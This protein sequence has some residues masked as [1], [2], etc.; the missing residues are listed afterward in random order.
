M[1]NTYP[2]AIELRKKPVDDCVLVHD[3]THRKVHVLNT[4]AAAILDLCD[5]SRSVEQITV[6]LAQATDMQPEVIAGDV[7]AT[8]KQFAELEILEAS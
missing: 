1:Q 3:A 5:G 7:H 4:T 2:K 6:S 8:L